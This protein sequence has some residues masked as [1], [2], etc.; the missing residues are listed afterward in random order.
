M[1][2]SQNQFYSAVYLLTLLNQYSTRLHSVE[3]IYSVHNLTKQ[4]K[5]SD[6]FILLKI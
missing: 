6:D 2:V 3:S 4:H 1:Y 5:K